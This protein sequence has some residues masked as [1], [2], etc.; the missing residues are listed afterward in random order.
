MHRPFYRLDVSGALREK[1]S[2]MLLRHASE[3]A[4]E[5]YAMGRLS[6]CRSRRLE[7]HLASCAECRDRL[8]VEIEIIRSMKAA[9][10]KLGIR[11]PAKTRPRGRRQP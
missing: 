9:G 6:A 8:A 10:A 11:R 7:D 2:S 5:E 3:E 1:W 4:I